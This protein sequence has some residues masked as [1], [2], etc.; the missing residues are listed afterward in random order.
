MAR[1][2]DIA[3][4]HRAER[5][6][7]AVSGVE[8]SLQY[9]DVDVKGFLVHGRRFPLEIRAPMRNG[10]AL[11]T[12]RIVQGPDNPGGTK[13]RVGSTRGLEVNRPALPHLRTSREG[14]SD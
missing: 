12:I 9:G 3:S 1:H 11:D 5:A 13:L 4:E 7:A 2:D 14:F 10:A 8:R 6:F